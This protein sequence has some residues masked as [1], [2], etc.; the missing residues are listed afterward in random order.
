MGQEGTRGGLIDYSQG[1]GRPSSIEMT[2]KGNT[3]GG[4][5]TQ[6]LYSSGLIDLINT[7]IERGQIDGGSTGATT[8]MCSKNGK[9]TAINSSV[10]KEKGEIH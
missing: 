2:R 3:E 7:G 6:Q 5:E 10:G 4:G 8:Y 1:K 9:C